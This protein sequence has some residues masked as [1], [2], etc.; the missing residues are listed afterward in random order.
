MAFTL[1]SGV[2][3]Q[4]IFQVIARIGEQRGIFK[5]G[6][7]GVGDMVG[8]FTARLAE[9]DCELEHVMRQTPS[10]SP[11]E[12][13]SV[14]RNRLEP[15][16]RKA[17]LYRI[18]REEAPE[19]FGSNVVRLVADEG[20]KEIRVDFQGIYDP[21]TYGDWRA[22]IVAVGADGKRRYSPLW[23]K[24]VMTLEIKPDDRR[25]WLCVAAT[26]WAFCVPQGDRPA[27]REVY[28]GRHAPRY[29]YEVQLV[30]CRPGTPHV[31]PGD[32]DDYDLTH[33]GGRHL[34]KIPHAGDTPEAKLLRKDLAEFAEKLEKFEVGANKQIEE[35]KLNPKGWHTRKLLQILG[36]RQ[37]DIH[38]Q[39]DGLKG[40]RHANGGG[41]VAASAK[42]SD[43]AYVG[44]DAM[45]LDGAQ[46]LDDAI[47]ENCAVVTGP[48][49]VVSGNAR[50]SGRA[51]VSGDVVL[52]DYTR[53]WHE[54]K[55]N[56]D[57]TLVAPTVPM[58]YGQAKADQWKLWANYSLDRD[59]TVVLED[60]LR[61]KAGCNEF[62]ELSLD[63]TLF[64]RPKFTVDGERLGFQFDGKTQYAEAASTLAD[65]G[66]ITVDTALKWDGGADQVVFDFGSSLDNRFVL[67]AAGKSGR[68]ELVVT[69]DGKSETLAA[70][71]ALPKGRWARCRV[72]IDGSAMSL[73]IDGKRAGTM[74]SDFRPC[75]AFT[76]DSVKRNFIAADR[77]GAKNFA[78]MIDF[79]RVYY[80]VHEDFSQVPEPRRH[81]PR[82]VSE[83]FIEYVKVI[84]G[85]AE[86][87]RRKVDAQFREEYRFY[88]DIEKGYAARMQEIREST[89]R[90]V[91][92]R[93]NIAKA[94]E[95]MA[96]RER[97]LGAE[98]DAQ[99]DTAARRKELESKR[100]ELEKQK[101]EMLN[102]VLA[103]D[104]VYTDARET[105]DKSREEMNRL[106]RSFREQPQV[107]KLA[108]RV[109]E[110]SRA[111]GESHNRINQR[112]DV[113]AQRKQ[114]DEIRSSRGKLEHE[115]RQRPELKA[116]QEAKKH[117]EF[118]DRFRRLVDSDAGIAKLRRQEREKNDAYHRMIRDLQA[119]DAQLQKE[120]A[121]RDAAN[122]QMSEM[123][124]SL[125]ATS[126]EYMTAADQY[127]ETSEIVRDRPR[128]LERS[129]KAVSRLSRDIQ[130][131][132]EKEGAIHRERSVYVKKDSAALQRAVAMAE[133][134]YAEAS[135]EAALAYS[136]E[137]RW[138][139]QLS[140]DGF[141][142]YYNT[143][144]RNYLRDNISLALSGGAGDGVMENVSALKSVRESQQPEAWRTRCDW[145]WRT[146]WE[147]DGSIADK[148]L[149]I[150]WLEKARGDILII[151]ED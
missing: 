72:E 86:Q 75:D 52:D 39:I 89:P 50:V 117:H 149:I 137:Y 126:Q 134:E 79:L 133:K 109:G 105:A 82:R 103:K 110:L 63:G 108:E 151:E 16:D 121:E 2:E 65:L 10:P 99:G 141:R 120:T 3:E 22:C 139:S 138:L 40:A 104:K 88:D 42:V 68:P 61:Y 127:R 80:T 15:V 147:L 84:S 33:T 55:G 53:T 43:T 91:A 131:V 25:H 6:I 58:R 90:A 93:D 118:N 34:C 12:V 102:E 114:L 119:A 14:K 41:W 62:Y 101:H 46:V 130:R 31:R 51:Y 26:P 11:G 19:M 29:P 143:P 122:R 146:R 9:L 8:E 112:E 67:C 7:R 140:T 129:N 107:K 60:W 111:V 135:A 150:K 70:D 74:K 87:M 123:I 94:K 48:K 145:Q 96:Q 78:G 97:E 83:E 44:P 136:Q 28:F 113:V 37:Q 85:N 66:E 45:V 23:N 69:R 128:K 54:I 64:G 24:G 144:Y 77:Q 100:R 106:E 71:R 49:A 98:F 124:E 115:I 18:F 73:W 142:G 148:S 59:E 27:I 57:E 125:R 47:I 4:T 132:R 38:R 20:A 95:K 116:L 35:G 13:L 92:A 36:E 56:R 81:A 17:G 76:P 30:G 5:N 1:H 32:T 21:A